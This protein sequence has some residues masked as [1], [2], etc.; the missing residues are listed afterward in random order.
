VSCILHSFRVLDSRFRRNFAIFVPP[1]S[2]R[3]VAVSDNQSPVIKFYNATY[4]DH[5]ERA[6]AYRGDLYNVRAMQ[7][8]NDWN[9]QARD[10]ALSHPHQVDYLLMRTEDLVAGSP[11][12]RFECLSA[13][14][15]FV[16]SHRTM[17]EI[18][19]QS[20]RPI[21]DHGRSTV[22]SEARNRKQASVPAAKSRPSRED[23]EQ[24]KQVA[25]SGIENLELLLDLYRQNPDHSVFAKNGHFETSMVEDMIKQARQRAE[26]L[27]P[28]DYEYEYEA[29]VNVATSVKERYGKWEG[30]LAN[31]TVLA[32]HLYEEGASGL[33]VFG[34]HPYRE[35]EYITDAHHYICDAS[36]ACPKNSG[37]RK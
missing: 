5:L 13:L 9:T 6:E 11:S 18:C 20:R 25:L 4:P 29:E 24:K 16:G 22:H 14:S 30:I 21:K 32:A 31:N 27:I 2:G 23:I 26:K 15:D 19:C 3:D 7:L 37:S 12:K 1:R 17:E 28:E 35:R 33:S 36:V 8:W 10:W 34:Y